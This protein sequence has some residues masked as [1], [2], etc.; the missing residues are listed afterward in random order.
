MRKYVPFIEIRMFVWNLYADS[1]LHDSVI[2]TSAAN[3]YRY[4][5]RLC[6]DAKNS[7]YALL[8]KSAP[9]HTIA[10]TKAQLSHNPCALVAFESTTAVIDRMLCLVAH[11]NCYICMHETIRDSLL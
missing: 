2:L 7:R 6:P 1:F 3:V 11:I 4:L 8:I 9:K 5:K 10:A